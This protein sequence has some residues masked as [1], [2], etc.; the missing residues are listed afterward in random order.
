M[1]KILVRMAEE[2]LKV[3]RIRRVYLS[4][5]LVGV[6]IA[7]IKHHDQKQIGE[8][9]TFFLAYTST[10]LSIIGGSQDRDESWRQKLMQRPWREGC[11]LLA[12]S[13]WLV[14]LVFL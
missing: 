11:Y 12:C 5:V 6:T 2:G 13:S 4:G 7:G 8:E 14:Q 10:L 9:R 1:L 3:L